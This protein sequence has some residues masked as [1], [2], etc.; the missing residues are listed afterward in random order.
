VEHFIMM[1]EA[2]IFDVD[3]TLVDSVKFHAKAWQDAFKRFEKDVSFD[4]IRRQVGKG[5]DQLLPVFFTH[6]E[7]ERFG[8]ELEDF[9][10]N[11]FRARYLPQVKPFPRVR[12]LLVRIRHDGAKIA[13]ASSAKKE[14]LEEYK[15][16]ARI[17]DLVE[18]ETS[19][20]DVDRSKPYPDIF[21][22]AL[23][24]LGDIDR[25]SVITVGDTP[26]DAEASTAANLRTIGLLNGGW[27]EESLRQ[28]GCI[29]VY[30]HPA[31]LLA[32]YE[33]SLLPRTK[34]SSAVR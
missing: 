4:A 23:T 30:C 1:I 5:G 11:L 33:Y 3:G 16:I 31:D 24:K 2:V 21:E 7:L 22:V 27:S 29:S 19:S 28:A 9:R 12:E 25:D 10:G 26:Y 34:R 15:K 8:R 6:E 18:V 32:G 13:L 17:E 14:E 20:N